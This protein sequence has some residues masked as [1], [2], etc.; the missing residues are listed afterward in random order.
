M[1]ALR[2]ESLRRTF[3]PGPAAIDGVDLA[4]ESGQFFCLLGPSG[5]G[6]TTLLRLIGGYLMPNSGEIIIAGQCLTH[7]PPERR[8]VGMVFQNYAL[9]PHL[10]AR[11][12]VAFGLAVRGLS[13]QDRR[14]RVEAMLDRVGLSNSERR[15]YPRELSGGQQQRVALARAL[16][17]EPELLLLDEP[18]ANLDRKLRERLRGEL[19]DIQR[20]TG[21]TTILVTHDQDE[22]FS[23][24]D[25]VGVM[26]Q[27]QFLQIDSPTALY[28]QPATL[29]VAR[30]V[31]EANLFQVETVTSVG[32]QLVGGLQ[33]SS[34]LG[35]LVPGT[36]L[37]IRPEHCVAGRAALDCSY[38]W[39]AQ[40]VESTFLGSDRLLKVEIFQ[41]TVLKVRGRPEE[42][43][44]AR[45]G[46]I[47]P[48][49]FDRDRIWIVPH[50]EP[51]R[52][53]GL[54]ATTNY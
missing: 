7:Q 31:G 41:G 27:G 18:L 17:I 1:E 20:R 39:Q 15:R 26:M 52:A 8:N 38:S 35:A 49:G 16:A 2:I 23:M 46:D 25:R 30:F 47:L 34:L 9:F 36:W 13:R 19:R 32:V 12:N 21:V 44:P 40:V 11:E 29:A 28:Q 10:S 48:V 24:A 45:V 33:F 50:Y 5:C 6:K 22:A 54:L 53:L 3:G 37:L 14:Q 51:A 42:L 43:P 4:V